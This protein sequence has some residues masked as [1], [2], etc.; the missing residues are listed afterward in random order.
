MAQCWCQVVGRSDYSPMCLSILRRFGRNKTSPQVI[1]HLDVH[2]P[3]LCQLETAI[4]HQRVSVFDERDPYAQ[5]LLDTAHTRNSCLSKS[6]QNC[7]VLRADRKAESLRLVQRDIVYKDFGFGPEPKNMNKDLS[8][9]ESAHKVKFQPGFYF[10]PASLSMTSALDRL[11]EPVAAGPQ[12]AYKSPPLILNN[13]EAKDVLPRNTEPVLVHG[14]Q[15]TGLLVQNRYTDHVARSTHQTWLEAEKRTCMERVCEGESKGKLD[16]CK[17][18]T[19]G[20]TVFQERTC[21]MC[22][23]K[24]GTMLERHC[25]SQVNR[26]AVAFYVLCG[27]LASFI[28]IG[29]ATVVYHRIRAGRRIR[30]RR[31]AEPELP[32]VPLR[33]EIHNPN[34]ATIVEEDGRFLMRQVP[35]SWYRRFWPLSSTETVDLTAHRGGTALEKPRGRWFQPFLPQGSLALYGP[36][37]KRGHNTEKL[38]KKRDDSPTP[39]PQHR[40]PSLPPVIGTRVS[41][42]SE[43]A[44][45]SRHPL[46]Q[47]DANSI[48]SSRD[49]VDARSSLDSRHNSRRVVSTGREGDAITRRTVTNSLEYPQNPPFIDPGMNVGEA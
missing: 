42:D 13:E 2:T 10:I 47:I 33:R 26:E 30:A 4:A 45:F 24:T 22:F 18:N 38:Q 29:I 9:P 36:A 25:Q 40:S 20:L 16:Y 5:T 21:K 11:F 44:R 3:T 23:S 49:R 32:V 41:I 43:Y 27:M 15:N 19:K 46:A 12:T 7:M 37:A 34:M 8:L 48:D 14:G 35:K 31:E 39:G 17:G 6:R 28:M 1:P